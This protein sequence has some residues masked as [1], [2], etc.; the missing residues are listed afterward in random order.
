MTLSVTTF[1]IRK[2]AA[3]SIMTLR[4]MTLGV[5]TLSITT[6]G[7]MTISITTLQYRI[8]YIKIIIGHSAR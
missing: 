2:T 6:L 7:I 3:F 1:I 5:M 4:K 8:Q